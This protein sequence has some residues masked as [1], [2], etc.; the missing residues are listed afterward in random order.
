MIIERTDP[1]TGRANSMDL[2]I[3]DAQLALWR[4]GEL[5]QKAMPNLNPDEREFLMTGITPES[6]GEMFSG[7]D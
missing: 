6:W 4:S 1:F 5:I 3:T 2:D 7:E